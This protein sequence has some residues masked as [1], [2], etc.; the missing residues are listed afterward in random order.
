MDAWIDCL[1]T[2]A[3]MNFAALVLGHEI[4]WDMNFK[5]DTL[6]TEEHQNFTLLGYINIVFNNQSIL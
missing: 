4:T 6:S 3:A 1:H 5:A 2:L